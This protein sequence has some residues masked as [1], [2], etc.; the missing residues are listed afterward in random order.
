LNWGIAGGALFLFMT[1]LLAIA[2]SVT[3][4]ARWY[5]SAGRH[6]QADRLAG[7]HDRRQLRAAV[8][9]AG[10]GAASASRCSRKPN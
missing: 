1:N 6:A 10:A 9:P 5:G 2:L 3:I 7:H 8:D 4:V